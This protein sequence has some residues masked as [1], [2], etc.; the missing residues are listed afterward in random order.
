MRTVTLYIAMSLD[1]YI[2][3][4]RGSVN[5]LHGHGSDEEN[6]DTYSDFVKDMDTVVM[7]WN[8]Y[9]QVATELSPD[10][11][12]YRQLT[13]YVITHRELPSRD[14]IKF[15]RENPC[16]LVRKL[17]QESGKGIWI[18]G[19][20]NIIQPLIRQGLIDTYYISVIPVILGSGIRLFG[21]LSSEIKLRLVHT[22][23]YNGITELV[24]VCR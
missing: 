1:G 16:S 13:S 14:N 18:C 6:T 2:A 17:K 20:G 24:Y 19:G 10:E 15:V 8:T 3:D 23:T 5:W 12:V 21:E 7:G 11:W 9:H 22:Q 4:R